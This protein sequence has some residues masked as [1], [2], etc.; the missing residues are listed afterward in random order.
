MERVVSKARHD[1]LLLAEYIQRSLQLGARVRI[2]RDREAAAVIIARIVQ[3]SQLFQRLSAVKIRC[4]IVRICFQYRREFTHA[5]FQI[6][7]FHVLHGQSVARERARGVLGN[8]LLQ[9][10]DAGRFQ[11]C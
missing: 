2:A 9:D 5:T 3:T 7:G 10:F 1:E 11:Q 6:T 8:E 4:G